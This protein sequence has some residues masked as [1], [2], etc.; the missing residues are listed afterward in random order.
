MRA[1]MR[2]R[3]R[4]YYT[5]IGTVGLPAAIPTRELRIGWRRGHDSPAG[6]ASGLRGAPLQSSV[7]ACEKRGI[8]FCQ[9]GGSGAT[10][11]GRCVGNTTRAATLDSM[12]EVPTWPHAPPA[13]WPLDTTLASGGNAVG[14]LRRPISFVLALDMRFAPGKV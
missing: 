3:C 2:S 10:A 9:N 6:A 8:S 14:S 4:R 11:F 13:P 5:K 12:R 7:F 1:L